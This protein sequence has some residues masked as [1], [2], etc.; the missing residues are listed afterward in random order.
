[1][2]STGVFLAKE[3]V[4]PGMVVA[5]AEEGGNEPLLAEGTRQPYVLKAFDDEMYAGGI[6]LLDANP[7]GTLVKNEDGS[8]PGFTRIANAAPTARFMPVAVF[9]PSNA[10]S[11]TEYVVILHGRLLP[12]PEEEEDP[13]ARI[14][15]DGDGASISAAAFK[16]GKYERYPLP[17]G[18]ILIPVSGIGARSP[19]KETAAAC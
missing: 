13:D 2:N 16:R 8:F 18:V 5:L 15:I 4:R 11:C 12:S 9:A 3:Q 19:R 14:I 7:D 6:K 10:P 1:M 17:R